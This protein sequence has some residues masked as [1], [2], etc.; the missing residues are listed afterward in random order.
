V[1]AQARVHVHE[2]H[3]LLLQILADLVVHDLG[4]VLGADAGEELALR[5]RDAELVERVL[6]VLGTSSQVFE[7][8]SD[9]RRSSGCRRSRPASIGEPTWAAAWRRS[10]RAP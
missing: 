3:A 8:F 2:D 7:D 4:L 9:A 10:A 5:L 6:D 1:L